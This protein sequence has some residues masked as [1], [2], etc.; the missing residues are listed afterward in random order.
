MNASIRRRALSAAATVTLSASVFG[1]GGLVASQTHDEPSIVNAGDPATPSTG[2]PSTPHAALVCGAPAVGADASVDDGTFACCRDVV[3]AT[4]GDSGAWHLPDAAAADPQVV[5]CCSAIIHHVDQKPADYAKSG[6]TL[7][8]CCT[9][10][11]YPIGVACTPWGPPVP[12][13]MPR[14]PS[15][16]PANEVA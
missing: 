9:A 4:L 13:E 10:V 6:S 15:S 14:V 5:A 11:H 2:A 3:A 7:G 1:C 8:P 16:A 12:P